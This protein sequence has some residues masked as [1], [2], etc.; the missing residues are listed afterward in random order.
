LD[1]EVKK[2]TSEY[3][4][5]WRN[6]TTVI[7][8][9]IAVIAIFGFEVKDVFK[10]KDQLKNAEEKI[11]EI[12]TRLAATRTLTASLEKS[13]GDA[14]AAAQ[15]AADSGRQSERRQRGVEKRQRRESRRG[16]GSQGIAGVQAGRG[17][18]WPGSRNNSRSPGPPKQMTSSSFVSSPPWPIAARF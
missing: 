17:P 18:M 11:K 13:A 14:R 4:K 2:R 12:D 7:S 9:L 15:T 10:L 16:D 8:G 3:W 1:V 5:K 6:W